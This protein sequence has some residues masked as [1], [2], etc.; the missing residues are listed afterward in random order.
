M[1]P[2]CALPTQE[3]WTGT[4][5]ELVHY[6]GFSKRPFSLKPVPDTTKAGQQQTPPNLD[7]Q[8]VKAGDELADVQGRHDRPDEDEA[9]GSNLLDAVGAPRC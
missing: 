3:H 1:A 4:T 2:F 6:V 7:G 9:T 5:L 8:P